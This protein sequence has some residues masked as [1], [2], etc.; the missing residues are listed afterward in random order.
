MIERPTLNSVEIRG[1]ELSDIAALTP[2]LRESDVL[3]IA[4]SS[5]DTPGSA[6]SSA[7]ELS[8]GHCYVLKIDDQAEALFGVADHAELPQVGIVWLMASEKFA[9][10]PDITIWRLSRVWLDEFS[11]LYP[12]LMN[13]VDARNKKPLRWLQRLGF[14]RIHLHSKFGSGELPFW[15]MMKL[16]VTDIR[17]LLE[18]EEDPSV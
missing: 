2:R 9:S 4:A 10:L 16:N 11:Q 13:Y 3:E 12:V 6:L 18:D 14:K 7:F 8:D 15:E 1:A 17:D 5:G